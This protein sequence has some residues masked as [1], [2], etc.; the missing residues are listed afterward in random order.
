MTLLEFRDVS[1]HFP[2]RRSLADAVLRRP[3]AVLRAVHHVDLSVDRGETLGIVGE[4]GCGKSTLARLAVGLQAADEGAVLFD[5]TPMQGPDPAG[6]IQM[7]F[8]DPYSSLNPRMTIGA[9]LEEVVAHYHRDLSAAERRAEA[10]EAL[11]RVGLPAETADK[12][13]HA[14]SGGQR[15]RVSIARALCPRPQILVADE[16]VSA[17]DASVQAQ[18]INLLQRLSA[19]TGITI[20]FI[21]HDM[22]VIRHLCDRV[23]VMYLGEVVELAPVDRLFD[24]PQ[25]PYTAGLMEAVPDIARRRGE[26]RVALGG[27]MPDPYAV[28]DGC[29]FAS[30]CRFAEPRCETP[31]LLTDAAGGGLVRCWKAP[32]LAA[33]SIQTSS[34]SDLT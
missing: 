1:R 30:R 16:P 28:I 18:I 14:L 32:P 20:L 21:S 12:Y 8:Q 4:S 7:V 6:R 29:R 31:Q 9:L 2:A 23:A 11:R 19:D 13:P 27:E 25:H 26:P 22:Q 17:L 24:Q 33:A 3:P 34:R 5:G 15:Q 10:G